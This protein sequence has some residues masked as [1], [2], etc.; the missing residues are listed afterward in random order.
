MC[1]IGIKHTVMDETADEKFN[2]KPNCCQASPGNR[3]R[4]LANKS[5]A[6]DIET[7]R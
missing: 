7:D 5:R 6:V 1:V 2:V 3:E 4:T